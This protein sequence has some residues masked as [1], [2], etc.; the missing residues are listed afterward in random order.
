MTVTVI[1]AIVMI[2][3]DENGNYASTED[4]SDSNLWW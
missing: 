3:I 2:M 4:N 1:I